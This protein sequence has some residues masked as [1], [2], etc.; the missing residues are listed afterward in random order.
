M[1]VVIPMGGLIEEL[2]KMPEVTAAVLPV[3]I[4]APKA[5]T[6]YSS[7]GIINV[8]K[9]KSHLH[10]CIP[11]LLQHPPSPGL[12]RLCCKCMHLYSPGCG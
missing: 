10:S 7:F 12:G 11:G 8:L 6:L 5:M 3:V 2:N 4:A 9:R 1:I